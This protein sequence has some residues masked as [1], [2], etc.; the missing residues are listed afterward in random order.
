MIKLS[1]FWGLLIVHMGMLQKADI[2]VGINTEKAG[3]HFCH[4]LYHEGTSAP[5]SGCSVCDSLGSLFRVMSHSR[6]DADTQTFTLS[7]V[8]I[9]N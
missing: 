2:K 3:N 4:S 5:E 9:L 6:A 1:D 8:P 7:S